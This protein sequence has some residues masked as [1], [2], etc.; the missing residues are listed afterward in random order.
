MY[1][2]LGLGKEIDIENYSWTYGIYNMFF[3]YTNEKMLDIVI[4]N[5]GFVNRHMKLVLN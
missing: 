3:Y 2:I 5:V 1:N 4:I